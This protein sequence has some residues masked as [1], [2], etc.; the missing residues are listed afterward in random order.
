MAIFASYVSRAR[1][2]SCSKPLA[3][4]RL[5]QPRQRG[6]LRLLLIWRRNLNR[7][8]NKDLAPPADADLQP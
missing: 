3:G 7:L 5:R 4:M 2:G 1:E 6:S 8:S